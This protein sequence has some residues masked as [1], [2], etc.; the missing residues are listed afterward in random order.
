MRINNRAVQHELVAVTR[1]EVIACTEKIGNIN[2]AAV[3]MILKY[4]INIKITF[5]YGH[6]YKTLLADLSIH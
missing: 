3:N 4:T 5:V 2:T 1:F 6:L